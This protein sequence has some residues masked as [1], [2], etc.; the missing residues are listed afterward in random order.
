MFTL[1]LFIATAQAH[2]YHE[3]SPICFNE[4]GFTPT[5]QCC[6]AADTLMNT[7][8]CSKLGLEILGKR[9]C[10]IK[11]KKKLIRWFGFGE[12]K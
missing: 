5:D 10:A 8:M 7:G 4:H 6:E 12:I 9:T 3:Y 1:M 11:D 2:N